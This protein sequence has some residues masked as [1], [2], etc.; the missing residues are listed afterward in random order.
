[1]LEEKKKLDNEP[2]PRESLEKMYKDYNIKLS[3]EDFNK[4]VEWYTKLREERPPFSF[5]E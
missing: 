1:M 5:F 2:S 4:K 3:E